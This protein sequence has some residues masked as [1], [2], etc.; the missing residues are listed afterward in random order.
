M[1]IRVEGSL[2]QAMRVL[3]RKLAKEGVFKEIASAANANVPRRSAAAAKNSAVAARPRCNQ[4]NSAKFL[5]VSSGAGE[6]RHLFFFSV[7]PIVR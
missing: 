4:R 3:K 2:D 7:N 1:E 6:I 5:T